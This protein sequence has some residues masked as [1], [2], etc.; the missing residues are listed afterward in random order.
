[1]GSLVVHFRRIFEGRN[2]LGGLGS[3]AAQQFSLYR[4]GAETVS[5]VTF[6]RLHS[7]CGKSGVSGA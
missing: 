7:V 3:F 2:R 4:M 5:E 6:L 1:M